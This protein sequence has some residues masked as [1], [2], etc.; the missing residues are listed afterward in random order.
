MLCTTY[1]KVM[2]PPHLYHL[3]YK[4]ELII[5]I[6]FHWGFLRNSLYIISNIAPLNWLFLLSFS[7]YLVGNFALAIH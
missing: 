1:D 7:P 4:V 6:K 2:P 5:R 3:P